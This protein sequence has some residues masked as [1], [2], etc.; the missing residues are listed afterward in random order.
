MT[1]PRPPRVAAWLAAFSVPPEDRDTL[2]GDLEER[3]QSRARS[4][5]N[6]FAGRWYWGQAVRL[7]LAVLPRRL[8]AGIPRV[9]APGTARS[10]LRSPSLRRR[11]RRA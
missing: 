5:G 6:R 9:I 8:V 10:A 3:F 2:L 11:G 4:R 7:S 1:H